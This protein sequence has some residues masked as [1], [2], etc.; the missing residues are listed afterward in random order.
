MTVGVV[1][2]GLI[3]GSFVKAYHQA[4]HKV[5]IWNRSESILDYVLLSGEAD[6]RLDR[7]TVSSCDLILLCIYPEAAISWL[8]DIAP[9][10]GPGPL[11]MDCCGTKTVICRACFPLAEEYGFTFLG[12]HPMAGTQY[13]G[14]KHARAICTT[15]RPWCWSRRCLTISSCSAAPGICWL[16]PA[17]GA[18]P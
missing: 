8:R 16:R 4:G 7:D 12:G 18:F 14:Y 15:G 3:G 2:L 10:I 1:G 9:C 5:L 13:S 17:L 11:V 6:G